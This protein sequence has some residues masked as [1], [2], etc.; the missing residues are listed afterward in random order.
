M[1]RR[2]FTKTQQSM[3]LQFALFYIDNCLFLI[4]FLGNVF[5]FNFFQRY[6]YTVQFD[7]L[8]SQE[9]TKNSSNMVVIQ[10]VKRKMCIIPVNGIS[11][12]IGFKYKILIIILIAFSDSQIDQ[13]YCK[14]IRVN[15]FK[16]VCFIGAMGTK[17][18]EICVNALQM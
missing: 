16:N 2:I 14:L 3:T 5:K 17:Y 4:F 15:Q 7:K 8:K 10:I 9:E 6:V 18:Q 13:V 11:H 1:K 12:F